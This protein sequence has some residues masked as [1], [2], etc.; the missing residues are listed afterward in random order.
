MWDRPPLGQMT[1]SELSGCT[2]R[3]GWLL[4]RKHL[5]SHDLFIK[6]ET[7]HIDMVTEAEDRTAREAAS[8]QRASS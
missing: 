6:L 7:W 4:G 8:R 2:E 1:T 3:A 5:L